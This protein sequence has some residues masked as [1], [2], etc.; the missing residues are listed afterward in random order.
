[1][2]GIDVPEAT[3]VGIE[4]GYQNYAAVAFADIFSP[5]SRLLAQ[6]KG[7]FRLLRLHRVNSE[8]HALFRVIGSSGAVS[9]FDCTLV[10][11]ADGKVLIADVY[12]HAMG[13][14][15][16]EMMRHG[17]SLAYPKAGKSPS[18]AGA[19]PPNAGVELGTA[20]TDMQKQD[21]TGHYQAAL[22]IYE[23]LS[24]DLQKEKLLLYA[25]LNAAKHL[26]GKPYEAAVRAYRQHYPDDVSTSLILIDA[27]ADHKLYDRE[28][29]SI[30]AVDRAVGGDP[31][32]DMLRSRAFRMKGDLAAAKGVREQ[33]DRRRAGTETACSTMILISQRP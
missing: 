18:D 10:R 1:M 24:P 17:L 32:L 26:K 3:R 8:Q 13:T 16:A 22:D 4:S 15:L 30:D 23:K 9:Y 5:F 28:L 21:K 29:A 33:G 19:G 2:A 6:G 7:G 12:I 25:R 11:H 31:Y 20:W 14:S 27:Y